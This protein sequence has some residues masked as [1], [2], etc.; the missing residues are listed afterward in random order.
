MPSVLRKLDAIAAHYAPA[1]EG[2]L[3]VRSWSSPRCFAAVIQGQTKALWPAWAE[4]ADHALASAY[5]PL[6]WETL[7]GVPEPAD[8]ALPLAR[9]LLVRPERAAREMA[10]PCVLAAV[11]KRATAISL[12]NDSVGAGRLFET[13]VPEGRFWSNRPGALCLAAGLQPRADE[14]AWAMFG[15]FGWFPRGT[16]PLAGV[17]AVEGSSIVSIDEGGVSVRRAPPETFGPGDRLPRAQAAEAFAADSI[18]RSRALG[19]L[20][21][22]APRV[23]LSGGRDSRITAAAMVAARVEISFRTSDLTPGEADVA[24]ALT[25]LLPGEVDHKIQWEQGKRKAAASS[26]LD[27]AEA[28]HL[29][30]DGLRHAGKLR[31]Q[32]KLPRPEPALA[33]VSGHGGAVAK[34][35]MYSPRKLER[36]EGEGESR[37]RKIILRSMRRSHDAGTERAYALALDHVEADLAQGRERGIDG[38][39]LLD[40]FYLIERFA[41]RTALAADVASFTHFGSPSFVRAALA[42]TP[43]ERLDLQLHRDVLRILVPAWS[44]VPFFEHKRAR[45]GLVGRVL[46]KGRVAQS[47]RKRDPVWTGPS[48]E[49]LRSVVAQGGPWTAMFDPEAVS[50]IL[51]E[52]DA[53]RP[54]P[55]FQ[56]PLE[57][58]LYRTAF[59]RHLERLEKAGRRPV[60]S[61]YR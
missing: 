22:R 25:A 23:N 34:G 57:A 60:D 1:H 7:T 33:T 37:I 53:G 21:E 48:G 58:I 46:R 17:A 47:D 15:A 26:P 42:M 31:G 2:E 50:R 9:E 14:D 4:D 45:R 59:D 30:H 13:S 24:K 55:H 56:D 8:A 5:V 19:R 11:D 51:T 52:I 49:E 35:S 10:A 39:S 43:S 54:H 27:R 38:A 29:V 36:I 32:M 20:Y 61:G 6:E 18:A 44:D 41:R 16:T 3:S 40:W 12:M 28:V